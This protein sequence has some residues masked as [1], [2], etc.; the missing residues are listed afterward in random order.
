MLLV[1]YNVATVP[2]TFALTAV[3]G[4]VSVTSAIAVETLIQQTVEDR[5]RGR[6]YGSLGGPARCSAWPAPQHEA[7][8]RRPSASSRP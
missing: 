6:V 5:Y 2:L 7:W 4:V 1:K 8:S 3:G